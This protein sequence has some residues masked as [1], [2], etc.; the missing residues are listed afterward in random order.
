MNRDRHR[1]RGGL[2]EATLRRLVDT[3]L[4]MRQIA[5]AVGRSQSTVRHWL[6]EFGMKTKGGLRRQAA[7]E[8][9]QRIFSRCE[10]HGVTTFVRWPSSGYRCA[11]CNS[12]AVSE[13]RRQVKRKLVQEAGG[14]CALCGYD[15]C[16]SALEFHHIDPAEKRFELSRRGV[17]RSLERARTE[18]AKCMLLCANCHAEVEAGMASIPKPTGNSLTIGGACSDDP[19]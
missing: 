2:D 11:R 5:Q 10:R 7:A 12:E 8:G 4:S 15:G 17:S 14:C 3:G 13:R 18:A 6:K 19:G 9:R 16:M 1:A